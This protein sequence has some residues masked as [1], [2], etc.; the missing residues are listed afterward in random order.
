MPELM[1]IVTT[2]CIGAAIGYVTYLLIYALNP[3]PLRATSSWLLAFLVNVVRQHGLHRQLTF[4]NTGPYWPSLRRAYLMYSG[5]A[6]ATT[7]L[8][9]ILAVHAGWNHNLAWLACMGLTATI[10]T[11]FLKRYVF[12]PSGAGDSGS[13]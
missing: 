12:S 6:V 10:S 7:L 5:S 11:V 2:A 13:G 4:E 8:N 9:W 3:L 1:R